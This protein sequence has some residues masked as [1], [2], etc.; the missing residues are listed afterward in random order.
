L[1]SSAATSPRG[2]KLSVGSDT[3]RLLSALDAVDQPV[4]A[5]LGGDLDRFRAKYGA[6][7]VEAYYPKQDV[8][9]EVP[10]A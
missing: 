5:T 6:Q 7:D 1:R 3:N 10:L 8:A 9:V 4:D 2:S